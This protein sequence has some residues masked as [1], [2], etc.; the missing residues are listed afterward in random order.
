[1]SLRIETEL[2]PCRF[3]NSSLGVSRSVADVEERESDV[4]TVVGTDVDPAR[5][6]FSGL[7]SVDVVTERRKRV[8]SAGSDDFA[9][10]FADLEDLFRGEVGGVA[11]DLEIADARFAFDAQS[12]NAR[13]RMAMRRQDCAGFQ[14]H[15]SGV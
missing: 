14:P 5:S 9:V 4:W 6:L 8:E 7:K 13:V 10:R 2:L 3:I 11:D 1:V 12:T 15:R